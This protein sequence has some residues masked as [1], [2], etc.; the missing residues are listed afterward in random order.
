MSLLMRDTR[1]QHPLND[2]VNKATRDRD[3]AALSG[4]AQT[5][6]VATVIHNRGFGEVYDYEDYAARRGGS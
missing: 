3:S 1:V 4:E 2:F 5:P 6:P